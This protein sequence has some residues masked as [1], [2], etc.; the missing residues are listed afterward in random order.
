[1]KVPFLFGGLESKQILDLHFK[2]SRTD[3]K[4]MIIWKGM[5]AHPG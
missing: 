4:G 2:G 3:S 1:M 5:F